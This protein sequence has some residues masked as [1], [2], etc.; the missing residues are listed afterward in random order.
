MNDPALFGRAINPNTGDHLTVTR[1]FADAAGWA[2]LPDHE[3]L[4]R[5]GR[6]LPPKPRTDLGERPRKPRTLPGAVPMPEA[7]VSADPE[8]TE[9]E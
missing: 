6:P 7:T 1:A 4:D 2:I 8:E 3:A 5:H 9:T